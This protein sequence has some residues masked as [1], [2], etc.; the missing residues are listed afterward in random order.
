MDIQKEMERNVK[1]LES[2][3]TP[4]GL[5]LAA[6][7]Q[8]TGYNKAW[9]RDNI[10]ASLGLEVANPSKAVRALRGLFDVMKKHE[11]KIYWAIREKPVHAYQYIHARYDPE[12]L[13]EFWDEWG[14]NRMMLSGLSFSGARR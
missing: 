8:G 12:T 5:L 1:L 3:Q 4:K 2:L 11:H 7:S 10:Y 13:E 9:I 6:P 14:N